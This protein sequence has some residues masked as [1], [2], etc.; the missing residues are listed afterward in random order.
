MQMPEPVTDQ[1]VVQVS[2][3]AADLAYEGVR[4]LRWRTY[5]LNVP[6]LYPD[7][8]GAVDM[9][10]VREV[11]IR[12]I[13]SEDVTFPP[14]TLAVQTLHRFVDDLGPTLYGPGVM[15]IGQAQVMAIKRLLQ[16]FPNDVPSGS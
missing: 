16:E 7:P 2:D 5:N 4:T 13:Q 9:E 12:T 8:T 11:L 6:E 15:H 14:V 3:S 10:R 1:D